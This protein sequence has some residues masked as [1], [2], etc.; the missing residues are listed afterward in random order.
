MVS[1]TVGQKP[2]LETGF[3]EETR[4]LKYRIG[5]NRELGN[6]CGMA[7]F[8]QLAI[9][10]YPLFISQFPIRELIIAIKM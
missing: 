8:V 6:R 4:F 1:D 10:N 5:K 2:G 3:L 9:S 7:S